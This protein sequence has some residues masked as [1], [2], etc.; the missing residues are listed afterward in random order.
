MSIGT[1]VVGLIVL[2]IVAAAVYSLVRDKKQ[3]KASCGGSC[4]ACGACGAC[5]GHCAG[6]QPPKKRPVRKHFN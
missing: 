4:G 6:C 1:I 5:S 3:G 2:A